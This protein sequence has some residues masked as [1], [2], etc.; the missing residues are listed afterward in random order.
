MG[1]FDK[2]GAGGGKIHVEAVSPA[3]AGDKVTGTLIF[4]GGKRAQKVTVMKVWLVR[5]KSIDLTSASVKDGEEMVSKQHD[6]GAAFETKPGED[7]RIPFELPISDKLTNSKKG[8]VE[9]KVV[10]SADIAGEIDPQGKSD[11][12]DVTGGISWKITMGGT[13]IEA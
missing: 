6:A 2:F 13:S 10:A 3:K 8:Y 5:S 12:I 9:Y 11:P 4:T 7:T 1:F